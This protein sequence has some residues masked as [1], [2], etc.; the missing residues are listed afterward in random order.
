[1]PADLSI[2]PGEK[3]R[4]AYLIPSLRGYRGWVSLVDGAIR[5][6]QKFVEPVLIVSRGDEAAAEEKFPDL[7]RHA[8]PTVQAEDWNGTTPSMLRRMLP[9]LWTARRLRPLRVRMVHSLEM[10]PAGWAGDA[11]ARA[12]G[13]PH[14][15][16]AIGTYTVLWRKWPALEYFYR[17]VLRRA[18]AIYPISHG[19]EAK[20]RDFYRS[21]LPS[22]AVH[23]ILC[24]T[25]AAEQVS[26]DAAR[27]RR[28][29]TAP[30]VLSVGMV[31]PRKGYHVNL[32][33]FTVLQK[34][35]PEAV[36]RIAGPPPEGE[37]RQLLEGIVRRENL[38]GVQFLGTVDPS[39]LDRLYREATIFLLLSQDL[40]LHFEGFGLVYLEAGAYGLPVVG[41][42]SGG[43]PDAVIDG[44]TGFLVDPSDAEAAG[45]AMIHL[46]EN[47][48]L[49]SQ[50]GLAGRSRAER[51]TWDRYAE[52]QWV[53][54]QKVLNR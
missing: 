46:A 11:L 35:F 23:T 48:V 8:L 13:I 24:G 22:T 43:I 37:Y 17:G 39:Q 15:L 45:M 19:T 44:E 33:A 32:R 29:K 26:P 14:V 2:L 27:N 18:A 40:D 9:A 31:K 1:M 20:L 38:V 53:E 28:E 51:L 12:G 34:R 21:D 10:F 49:S 52:E 50:M 6:L 16:T 5:S 25:R 36:Y 41:S 30:V 4:I 7:E 54:Y 3:P 42:R 47:P